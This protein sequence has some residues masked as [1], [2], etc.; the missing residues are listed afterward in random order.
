MVLYNFTLPYHEPNED[1]NAFTQY[2]QI[3]LTV[4]KGKA[5]PVTGPGGT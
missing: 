4:T 3:Y 2:L 1:L 5:I